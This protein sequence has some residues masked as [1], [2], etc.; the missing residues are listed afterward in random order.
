[1]Q[2]LVKKTPHTEPVDECGAECCDD[3]FT[4]T[5]PCAAGHRASYEVVDDDDWRFWRGFLV[6]IPVSII[7]W[8][9]IIYAW[10]KL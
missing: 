9:A 1:M 5:M 8:L 3:P 2:R 6:G 10:S 4:C 7:L